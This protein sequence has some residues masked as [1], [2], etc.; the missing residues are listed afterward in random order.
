M[1]DSIRIFSNITRNALEACEKVPESERFI[2]II[3]TNSEQWVA[4]EVHNSYNGEIRKENGKLVTTKSNRYSHGLGIGIVE[5]IAENLGG[6][7]MWEA[8]AESKTFLTRVLVPQIGQ[9]DRFDRTGDDET[10]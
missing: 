1:L 5:E 4:F 9:E 7:V 2:D 8:Q 6:F 10:P 3:S